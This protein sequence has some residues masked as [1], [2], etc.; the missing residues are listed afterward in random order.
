MT[1][2]LFRHAQ[3]LDLSGELEGADSVDKTDHHNRPT[4][5]SQSLRDIC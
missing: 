1:D 5:T 2:F 3:V 4:F